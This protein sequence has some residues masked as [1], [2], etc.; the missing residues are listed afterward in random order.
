MRQNLYSNI[1]QI[2]GHKLGWTYIHP[3]VR[4]YYPW[5]NGIMASRGYPIRV[6]NNGLVGKRMDEQQS[7]PIASGIVSKLL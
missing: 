7:T 6:P 5:F 4:A 2:N 3:I 1:K